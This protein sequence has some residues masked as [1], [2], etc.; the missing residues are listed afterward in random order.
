LR[1]LF[2]NHRYIVD[3]YVPAIQKARTNGRFGFIKVQDWEEGERLMQKIDGEKDRPK[4]IKVNWAKYP[5]RRDFGKEAGQA[6]RRQDKRKERYQD[7]LVRLSNSDKDTKVIALKAVEDNL[8]WLETSLICC[9]EEPRDVDLL[10]GWIK[11]AF[12]QNIL[13][14]DVGHYKFLLTVESKEAKDRLKVEGLE[15]LNQWFYSVSDW[16]ETE[17]CQT[18]RIWIEIVGL[19]L[20][21]W[22]EANIKTIAAK[23]GDVVL[24]EK[25]SANLESLASA[26]V[27]I[28]T[29]SMKQIEGKAIIQDADKGFTVSVFE[30]R[31]EFTIFHFDSLDKIGPD[32]FSP[33]DNENGGSKAEGSIHVEA[34]RKGAIA[35]DQRGGDEG[36]AESDGEEG[37]PE[38]NS[39]SN[40]KLAQ[41]TPRTL[42]S[43]RDSQMVKGTS[44]SLGSGNRGDEAA[45]LSLAEAVRV[46]GKV[47]E[48][49]EDIGQLGKHE[50]MAEDRSQA[51]DTRTVTA[52]LSGNNYSE[53][54]RKLNQFKHCKS[55]VLQEGDL[56]V[57]EYH[58]SG[59]FGKSESEGAPP[60]FEGQV[61]KQVGVARKR[62]GRC[63][64]GFQEEEKR[65]T[66]SQLRKRSA[67]TDG[68]SNRLVKSSIERRT[69]IETTDSMRREAEE[70]LRVG[71][72]LGIKVVSHRENAVKR[73]TSTLKANRAQRVERA[74]G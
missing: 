37:S 20:Q 66:R 56:E 74:E 63:S 26:K 73:I 1:E 16:N 28:D 65:V 17:V 23:W 34:I 44:L 13:V 14:R 72:I 6:V 49:I 12:Q 18:R 24:V 59:S 35:G 19:P 60:G 30:A 27:L 68:Y 5:R 53:E 51:S 4:G 50:A 43:L 62:N 22:S 2:G 29:L 31:S 33:K 54:V 52:E 61:L 15:R 70:A 9:S 42:G 57:E 47:P 7:E 25:E 67:H 46:L 71:E 41:V 21:F 69:S 64:K 10:K 36:Q 11:D 45:E 3:A 39:N 48:I 58:S 32:L 8:W 40:S 38:S 55:Q